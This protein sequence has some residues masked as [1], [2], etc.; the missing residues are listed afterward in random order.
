MRNEGSVL[1]IFGLTVPVPNAGEDIKSELIGQVGENQNYF[2]W[3]V[4]LKWVV[5]LNH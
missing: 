3:I 5:I 4:R 1:K 2:V